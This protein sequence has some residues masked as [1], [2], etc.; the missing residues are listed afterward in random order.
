MKFPSIKDVSK[1]LRFVD[2]SYSRSDLGMDDMVGEEPSIDV[3][4]QVYP[5][6]SWEIHTGDSQYDCDH[7][8]FWGYSSIPAEGKRFS[9]RELARELLDQCKDDFAQCGEQED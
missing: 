8:G 7:R 9:R 4:L 1:A 2:N 5:S 3:R 6:G